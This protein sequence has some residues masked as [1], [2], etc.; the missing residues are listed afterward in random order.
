M[1][2][3]QSLV[4]S[5]QFFKNFDAALVMRLLLENFKRPQERI[6]FLK[7]LLKTDKLLQSNQVEPFSNKYKARRYFVKELIRGIKAG[8][9]VEV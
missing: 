4:V 9:P 7:F 8:I 1:R 5:C 6:R 3:I 2:K